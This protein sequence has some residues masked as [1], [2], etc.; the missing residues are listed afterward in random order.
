MMIPYEES[1]RKAINSGWGCGYVYIPVE[2]KE[3]CATLECDGATVPGFSEEITLNQYVVIDGEKFL[4]IG[5]DTAHSWNDME[6][7]GHGEVLRLTIELCSLVEEM[8]ANG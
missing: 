6:N 8:V 5:F 1:F 2:Y 3:V 4:Q 7:S